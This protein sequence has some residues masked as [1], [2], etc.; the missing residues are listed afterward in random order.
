MLKLRYYLDVVGVNQYSYWIGNLLFDMIIIT[1]WCSVMISLVFPLKLLAFTS[2]IALYSGLLFSFGLAH[3]TFSYFV[4]FFFTSAQS[5]MKFFSFIYM[6][7]GFF[8]PFLIKNIMLLSLGCEAY[9]AAEFICQFIPL[10]P[11]YIG[12]KSL[13]YEQHRPF[14]DKQQQSM[15]QNIY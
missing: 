10:Q 14:L 12:F 2:N 13:I 15:D 4:S 3:I 9:H 5:A 1:F 11:L 8:F 7:G 6:T